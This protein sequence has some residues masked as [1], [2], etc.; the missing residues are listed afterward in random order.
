MYRLLLPLEVGIYNFAIVLFVAFDIFTNFGLDLFLIREASQRRGR[1]GYY[2]YNTSFF[3]LV[4]SLV[5]VPLLA[6]VML[7]WQSS[8]AE[9]IS[10]EGLVAIGFALHRSVPGQLVKGHDLAV[11]CQ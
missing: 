6:G 4:L 2:L 5:G 10:S 11:L 7:L 9:A 8:G 1:A 3:R